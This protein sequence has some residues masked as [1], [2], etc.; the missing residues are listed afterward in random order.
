MTIVESVG[1]VLLHFVW[2]GAVI[3]LAL[4]VLL[5]LT[6][7][8]EARLR[9]GFSCGAL[10]LMLITAVATAAT[11]MTDALGS[12]P[13][14]AAGGGVTF[15]SVLLPGDGRP[16]GLAGGTARTPATGIRTP[17]PAAA[18][19]AGKA[20]ALAQ[21]IVASA[22][23]WLVLGWLSGVLALSIRLLGG[24]WS[25]RSLRL[26]GVSPVPDWCK[27]QLT[28]LSARMRVG[29]PVAI[30]ASIRISVPVVLGHVKPV[31]VLPAAV[32]SGLSPAQLDAILAHELAHVR[33]HD[34]LVNL[35]QAVIETLLFYHPAVWWVSRQVRETREHCCDDLAVTVCRSRREY[36]HALLD[37]EQLRDSTPALALGATDGSLLARGRRLLAPPQRAASAPR[38]AASVI[39]LIVV[40]A[41]VAGASFNSASGPA[42]L[43]PQPAPSNATA[44]APSPATQA[45]GATPVTMAP[46]PASPLASRWAWAEGAARSAGRRAYWI[47]YGISPVKTLPPVIYHDRS[48]KV[49]GGGMTFSGQVLS[50]DGR[51]LRFPG[52]PLAVPA[53]ENHSVKVLFALD[54]SRGEARLTGVHTSTLSLPVDTKDRPVYWLGWADAA[55]SLDRIDRFYPSVSNSELKQDLISAAAVLDGSSA[56]VAWLERR[57]ASQDPDE[58]RGDAA[59]GIAWHPIAASITALD[60]TARADRSSRVRQEAAEALGDL[61]MP[62]AAPVLIALARTLPDRDARLEAVEALGA[63]REPAAS[64]ALVSIARTD[65]DPDIQREAVETLGDFDDKR[66][67]AAL[68][69]LARTHPDVEVRRKAVETLGD[70]MPQNLA[71]PMLKEFL[72]DRDPRVQAEA[73]DTIAGIE[74]TSGVATLMEL[75]RS[76]PN[77]SL[78]RE[79]VEALAQRASE[80]AAGKANADK[81]VVELLSTLAATDR[82]TDVQIEAVETLGEIGSA[83]AVAQLRKLATTHADERVRAEAI[84]S[85]GESDASR[86][87]TAGFL[88][89][90]ARAEK[91]QR[92]QFEALEALADLHDGAGIAALVALARSH[93]SA[94]TRQ[95]ALKRLLDSDHPD[96]RALF[97]RA[98]KKTSDR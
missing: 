43:E 71:V 12:P 83:A 50:S 26:V 55:Q 14:G 44:P 35:V 92:V 45:A 74:N 70:A 98:L 53:G 68:I 46:N 38:L 76:H 91:S 6:R 23:P 34:Y 11:V 77:T 59:E 95:E 86:T 88:E 8:G 93:P 2:Q 60:R 94:S 78:R 62:E 41:A 9:Y 4:A 47:G 24:W 20:S 54:A 56:V 65:T 33:R 28:A 27:A 79:A 51:G 10:T 29:R 5:A 63:R 85:L 73:V 52:R 96:A 82:E 61:A 58:V 90:L 64:D 18:S 13:A 39:A 25:T 66:G 42:R 17:P 57:I 75:A 84:E 21:P 87:E 69:E 97:E 72:G 30:I 37:L 89:Q 31:I 1:W 48:A 49:F 15:G 36:V 80:Q 22:M 7:D 19:P 32:L 40:A 16:G 81:A 3:A 67:I